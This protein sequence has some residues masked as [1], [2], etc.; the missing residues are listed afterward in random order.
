MLF[1]C[2]EKQ[3]EPF[4]D[5]VNEYST[6]V[7]TAQPEATGLHPGVNLHTAELSAHRVS[8]SQPAVQT[9]L[10]SLYV[11]FRSQCHSCYAS[12]VLGQVTHVCVGEE[13]TGGDATDRLVDVHGCDLFWSPV[14]PS[15]T[16]L[17]FSLLGTSLLG[18]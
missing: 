5:Q 15:V 6:L 4:Y 9:V 17:K 13:V 14:N 10:T 2:C 8:P 7:I 12:V 18:F 1:R 11:S 16:E 3:A